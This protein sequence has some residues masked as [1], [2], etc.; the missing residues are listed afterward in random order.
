MRMGGVSNGIKGY[1]KNFKDNSKY[2]EVAFYGGSFTAIDEK[3]QKLDTSIDIKKVLKPNQKILIQVKKD[4]D[5][6]K[7]ARVSTHI[8]MPGRFV[9]IM[10]NTEFITVSQ[11]IEDQEEKERE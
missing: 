4:S 1:L 6:K 7:G 5:N 9:V 11:K 8:S 10:P 3:K 2:V